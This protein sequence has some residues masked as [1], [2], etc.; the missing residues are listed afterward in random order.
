MERVTL[1]FKGQINNFPALIHTIFSWVSFFWSLWK[2]AQ[3]LHSAQ[4]PK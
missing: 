2:S 4:K 1:Y 3:A